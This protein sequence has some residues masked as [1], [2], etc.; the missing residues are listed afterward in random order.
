MLRIY[1]IFLAGGLTLMFGTFPVGIADQIDHGLTGFSIDSAY[2]SVETAH[3]VIDDAYADLET[4]YYVLEDL[5]VTLLDR[6]SVVG[7]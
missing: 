1:F 3:E 5:Y 4:A 2:A 7:T 6:L